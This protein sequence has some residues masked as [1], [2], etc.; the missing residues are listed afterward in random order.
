MGSIQFGPRALPLLALLLVAPSKRIQVFRYRG[1][2][3]EKRASSCELQSHN[4]AKGDAHALSL[5]F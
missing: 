1:P 5:Q 3:A 2:V 4:R